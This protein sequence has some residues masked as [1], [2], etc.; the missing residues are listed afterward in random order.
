MCLKT[1]LEEDHDIAEMAKRAAQCTVVD[2]RMLLGTIQIKRLQR[3]VWWLHDRLKH[4]QPLDVA[5][6]TAQ[7]MTDLM[8]KKQTEKQLGESTVTVKDL[9]KFDPDDF[10]TQEDALLNVLLQ[11]LGQSPKDIFLL[12]GSC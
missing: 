8:T 6:F 10:N 3:L 9:G 12:C 7:V 2:R 5:A 11:T 4:H 1:L